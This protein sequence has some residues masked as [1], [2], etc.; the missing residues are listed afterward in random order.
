MC[1]LCPNCTTLQADADAKHLAGVG[2][3]KRRAAIISGLKDS[4]R[5][6]CT[7]VD[8]TTPTEAMTLI[9]QNQH[10]DMLKEV[11]TDA[12]TVFVPYSPGTMSSVADEFRTSLMEADA[13]GV[14]L[15]RGKT[16]GA[17]FVNRAGA[18]HKSS[19]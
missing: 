6:F 2:L 7:E 16:R 18:S 12:S 10:L 9:M 3:A 15:G 14:G 1:V 17:V 5:E 8:G 11:G 4:V 19:P 13:A